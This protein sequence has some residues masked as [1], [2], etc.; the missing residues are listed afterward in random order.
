MRVL[1]VIAE[2]G[3]G[4]AETVAAD[5]AEHLLARGDEITLASSG[6]WRADELSA[7]GARLLEVPLRSAAAGSLA[8]SVLRLRHDVRGRPPDIVHSHNVRATFAAHLGTRWSRHRPRLVT[9][10]HGLSDAD[11][12]R[13]ARVLAHTADRVVAVSDHVAGR[14]ESAGLPTH[15]LVVIEN[16]VAP[17]RLPDKNAAR[18]ELDLEAT[19]RVAVCVARLEAPK[20]HDQLIEAWAALPPDAVLLVAG[21]GSGRGALEQRIAE[22][23]LG[24][25]VRLLGERRDV[26]RLLSAADLLVL[27]SDREGLPMAVLEAM[28]AGIPVV[29]SAVGGVADL[30]PTTLELVRPGSCRDLAAGLRRVLDDPVGARARAARASEA[31][32][33]RYSSSSMCSAYESVFSERDG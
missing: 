33:Q 4:G 10:V 8:R 26:P 22:A 14:L 12:P 25:R 3:S 18:R 28:A 20:R 11:Y 16:A 24:D 9:T 31:I 5:L 27:P 21:D 7:R 29:A 6:G 19:T 15:R 1:T 23:G 30:D 13:A 17:P 2:L 32:Q